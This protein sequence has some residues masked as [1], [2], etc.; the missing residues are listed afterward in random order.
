MQQRKIAFKRKDFFF[1]IENQRNEGKASER[2][3]EVSERKWG[4]V[5]VVRAFQIFTKI[6]E[7]GFKNIYTIF[8]IS[9][10]ARCY[11]PYIILV[12]HIKK[13]G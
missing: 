10:K 7:T 2:A 12:N 5:R 4:K 3:I 8:Y 9:T 6:T 13:N 11:K 1:H